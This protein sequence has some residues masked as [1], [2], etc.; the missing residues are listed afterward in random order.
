MTNAQTK[1]F[2]SHPPAQNIFVL[3]PSQMK[4]MAHVAFDVSRAGLYEEGL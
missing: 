1:I 4:I 2:P 3:M